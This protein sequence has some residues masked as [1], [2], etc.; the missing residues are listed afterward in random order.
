M[1]EESEPPFTVETDNPN[2]SQTKRVAEVTAEAYKKVENRRK[3]GVA[4]A[5][6]RRS[7]AAGKRSAKRTVRKPVKKTAKPAVTKKHAS[8]KSRRQKLA[9]S[10]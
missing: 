4:K 2:V 6:G 3:R 5:Q 10:R 9:A 8:V 7:V 1:A